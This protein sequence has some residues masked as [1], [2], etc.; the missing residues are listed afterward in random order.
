[1]EKV[2]TAFEVLAKSKN[3]SIE[4]RNFIIINVYL[5]QIIL[6]IKNDEINYEMFAMIE[7]G[8]SCWC[9]YFDAIDGQMKAANYYSPDFEIEKELFVANDESEIWCAKNRIE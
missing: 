7:W 5:Q 2:Q 6:G 8:K 4:K 3:K 1:M 9:W